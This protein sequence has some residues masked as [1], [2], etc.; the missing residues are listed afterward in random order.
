MSVRNHGSRRSD[1]TFPD[2]RKLRMPQKLRQGRPLA[3]RAHFRRRPRGGIRSCVVRG[4][5]IEADGKTSANT[6]NLNDKFAVALGRRRWTRRAA[7][8]DTTTPRLLVGTVR[9][10][11]TRLITSEAKKKPETYLPRK[12]RLMWKT[13]H[14]N[15]QGPVGGPFI[16]RHL[17]RMLMGYSKNRRRGLLRCPSKTVRHLVTSSS[18]SAEPPRCGR[19]T[20]VGPIRCF[21]PFHDLPPKAPG[22]LRRAGPTASAEVVT[23]H[24]L[25]MYEAIR[26]CR[27]RRPQGAHG[28]AARSTSDACGSAR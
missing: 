1:T 16:C 6:R 17:H 14:A 2:S 15:P 4:K 20:S 27:P 25:D 7:W 5:E 13:C 11:T 28:E 19:R 18:Y 3:R 24:R 12:A 8:D 10:P 22:P 26:A 9:P 21:K 23:I